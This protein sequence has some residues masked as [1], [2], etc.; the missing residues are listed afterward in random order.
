MRDPGTFDAFYS[1]SVRRVTG[2]LYA[3]TGSRTEAEDCVQ[4]AY[5]RAR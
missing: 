2:Q 3:M 4:E 5:A 1:G